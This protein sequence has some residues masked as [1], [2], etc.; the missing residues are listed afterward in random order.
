MMTAF[1]KMPAHGLSTYAICPHGF[2][3]T[4][5]SMQG[6]CKKNTQPA[7]SAL[8]GIKHG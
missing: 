2:D 3:P 7:H 8:A 1:T 4:N 5:S 6:G